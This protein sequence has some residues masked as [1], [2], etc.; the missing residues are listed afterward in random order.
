MKLIKL[1]IF[2]LSL[3]ILISVCEP[4]VANFGAYL[5]IYRENQKKERQL[6]RLVAEYRRKINNL[7]NGRSG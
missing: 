5:N 2:V 1:I 6:R 4:Q 3:F 7:P